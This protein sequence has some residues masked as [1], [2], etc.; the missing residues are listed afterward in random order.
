MNHLGA[1]TDLKLTASR[2]FSYGEY[3]IASQTKAC[4]GLVML[5]LTSLVADNFER[6]CACLV[7]FRVCVR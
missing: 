5:L 6:I 4:G 1:I 3:R 7:R 2:I